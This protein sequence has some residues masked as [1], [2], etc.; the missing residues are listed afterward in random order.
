MWESVLSKLGIDALKAGLRKTG[1]QITKR[2]Y[3]ILIS[4][5]VRELL[6]LHPD[7]SAAEAKLL[8]AEALALPKTAEMLNARRMLK[9][10]KKEKKKASKKRAKKKARKAA[11]KKRKTVAKK[12]AKHSARQNKK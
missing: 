12:K 3:T 10:V 9:A 5:A 2:E 7:I 1:K 11:G 6:K 8:A 4:E